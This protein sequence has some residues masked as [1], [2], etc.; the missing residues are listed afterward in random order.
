MRI[1]SGKFK[2]KQLKEVGDGTRPTR[3]FVRENVFNILGSRV[4]GAE[5]L[6]CFAG[7]GA[8][9]IEAISRGAKNATFF[10]INP[11]ACD[12]IRANLKNINEK[13]EV[14][15]KNFIT[16]KIEKKFDIIFID[17]P[18]DSGLYEKT[19]QKIEKQSLLKDGGIIVIE[20]PRDFNIENSSRTVFYGSSAVHFI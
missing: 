6:D 8:Y 9:G 16:A 3:D 4:I 11:R 2:G 17:P 19:I 10:D 1:I 20:T 13:Q 15:C 5:V 18:Y 7:T 12:I 14:K